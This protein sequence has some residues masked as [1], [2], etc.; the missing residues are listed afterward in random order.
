V[1]DAYATPKDQHI[2]LIAMDEACKALHADERDPVP[3]K[4]ARPGRPATPRRQDDKYVRGGTA[5]VFLFF[6]PLLGWRRATC[7]PRRTRIDF[8]REIKT[9]LT[10]DFPYARRVRLVCDNLNTHSIA[11]LYEAFEPA[12]AYALARRLEFVH[13][14]R[15]GSWLNVAEIELAALSEQCA[16]R[17]ITDA[18]TLAKE[19]SH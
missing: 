14:P 16:R 13:T 6:A 3:M 7:S 12:E 1:L 11:S 17:R 15:N 8:A 5:A 19:L 18:P 4:P 9:L 2:P 10:I